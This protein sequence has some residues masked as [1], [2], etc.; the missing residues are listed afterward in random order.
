MQA[1][2]LI[3]AT[4]IIVF[5]FNFCRVQVIVHTAVRTKVPFKKKVRGERAKSKTTTAG[6]IQSVTSAAANKVVKRQ[7]NKSD[8][9]KKL[10]KKKK[11]VSAPVVAEE[12]QQ[13]A[14]S[15]L[16]P[17]TSKTLVTPADLMTAAKLKK[18]GKSSKHKEI[19]DYS[20]GGDGHTN[21]F[22]KVQKWLLESPIVSQPLSQFEHS[23]KVQNIMNKSQSTP[24][25]L[26]QRSPKKVN[27]V[28][29]LNEKVKLQVVY[30]PPFKFSL[31]LSK[32]SSVKTKVIG[33]GVGK[34]KRKLRSTDRNRVGALPSSSK[35]T[36]LLVRTT[37]T[38]EDPPILSNDEL[39]HHHHPEPTYETLDNRKATDAPVY[40]NV[41]LAEAARKTQAFD[42]NT[43]RIAKAASS[44][45]DKLLGSKYPA[46]GAPGEQQFLAATKDHTNSRLS[47]NLSKQFG[48]SSQNLKRASTT[49]LSKN[50]SSFDTKRS[51]DLSRSST[52]NLTKEHRHGGSSQNLRRGSSHS[53]LT[54][55]ELVTGGRKNSTSSRK[56]K[57]AGEMMSRVPSNSSLSKPSTT[58][59]RRGSINNIPRASLTSKPPPPINFNRQTSLQG[60]Q[61]AGPA[62]SAGNGGG[63]Q[64]PHTASCA[65]DEALQRFEW[66]NTL[67]ADRRCNDDPLP[68]DLEVMC[69][70]VENL[71][72]DR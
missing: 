59:L 23:S 57:N 44:G 19:I 2:T 45:V 54:H 41:K 34:S 1:I 3:V 22:G 24:E 64:R 69:S 29:N 8:S 10:I 63:A 43:F 15:P 20:R 17:S 38:A 72:N 67:V 12:Q 71:V 26:G 35:R 16:Q 9:P 70:D 56:V 61:R 31:K 66:P 7:A 13:P 27:S 30:K 47:S 42:N 52:T 39:A 55:D 49:N 5:E 32:N 37:T 36:A 18:A 33:A 60:K 40:E 14:Q 53:N 46:V 50:R 58:S 48:G 68:S 25:R 6:K 4:I 62:S 28:G 51:H 21:T 11:R 65:A